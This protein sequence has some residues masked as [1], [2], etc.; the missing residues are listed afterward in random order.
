MS[1]TTSS[2]PLLSGLLFVSCLLSA[3][4]AIAA[5]GPC[6]LETGVWASPAEACRFSA[7]PDE[8]AKRFGQTALL[9]LNR[10]FY[11]LEGATC[12]IM[13]ATLASQTCTL[14]IE[15]TFERTRSL[16]QLDIVVSSARQLKLGTRPDSPVYQYCGGEAPPRQ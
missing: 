9:E 8:A 7:S 5:D 2:A 10:G 15:C 16:G 13:S 4:R 11:R 12:G 1:A 3:G 14:R 6:G